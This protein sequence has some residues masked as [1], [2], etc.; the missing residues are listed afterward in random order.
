MPGLLAALMFAAIPCGAR[1]QEPVSN[2]ARNNAPVVRAT[3]TAAAHADSV[4]TNGSEIA[5]VR[6]QPKA[7]LAGIVLSRSEKKAVNGILRRNDR[8]L[9]ALAA[10]QRQERDRAA[11]AQI[12]REIIDIR[13]RERAEL[14]ALLNGSKRERFDRNVARLDGRAS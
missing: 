6:R 14:R 1:A 2:M 8:V 5:F 13:D 12:E 11:R 7:L 4:P 9:S 3:N 10:R